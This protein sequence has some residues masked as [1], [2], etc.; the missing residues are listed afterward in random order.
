MSSVSVPS[1]GVV[2]V[3]CGGHLPYGRNSLWHLSAG[4]TESAKR[5]AAQQLTDCRRRR[6]VRHTCA[7]TWSGL[8]EKHQHVCHTA[9]VCDT[10][11]HN[12]LLACLVRT[13]DSAP[14]M[15]LPLSWQ[16]PRVYWIL[17]SSC[18]DP[19]ICVVAAFTPST[20]RFS[21]EI[22]CCIAS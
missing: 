2:H 16:L 1:V 10:V 21:Y 11:R 14:G 20:F 3:R 22:A 9:T 15:L 7:W 5:V 6:V 4:A 13:Q 19:V 18:V 17:P 8:H 12:S